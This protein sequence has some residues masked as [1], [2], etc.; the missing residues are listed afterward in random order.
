MHGFIRKTINTSLIVRIFLL[1][2]IC[3]SISNAQEKSDWKLAKH[4][5]Q[6]AN[7]IELLNDE[8]YEESL[9]V[10]RELLQDAIL[11]NDDKATGYAYNVI[12]ANFDALTEPDKAL[13]YYN[14]ALIYAEKIDDNK[15]LNWVNNNLGNIYC[16]DSNDYLKG[17][18]YYITSLKYS[19]KIKDSAQIVF[20]KLN[21]TWAYFDIGEFEKGAPY[22]KY[23]NKYH[24]RHG[25]DF[26]STALNL[27]N[28]MYA[29]HK[30]NNLAAKRYFE[31]AIKEGIR[32]NEKTDLSFTFQE[33]SKFLIKNNQPELAYHYLAKYD[34]L[35][36]KIRTEEK[37]NKTNITGIN[38]QVDEY[39]RELD[40]T[41]SLYR[42]KEEMLKYEKTRNKRVI[43]IMI[44]LF[45][46]SIIL[47]Y[48]FF[49]NTRLKQKNKLKDVQ[50]KIQDNLINASIDGQE[51]ERIEIAGFLHDNISAMLSSAGMHLKSFSTGNESIPE[52][53]LKTKDILEEAH[54]RVR[55]LSH[56]LLPSLL[57]R[58]GLFY[59]IED[60][61][62]KNSNSK[63]HFE[64]LSS[65]P[66]NTRY[67]QKFE[68]R[69]YFIISELLNNIS[70]HS[71]AD[72]AQVSID[73]G[74]HELIFHVHDNGKG[75]DSKKLKVEGFGLNQVRARIKNL[76]GEFIVNSKVNYG[77]SVKMRVPILY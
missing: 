67:N 60:L 38:L 11:T 8:K 75:F 70:K 54:D 43:G 31:E 36:S 45:I 15:L 58:F 20:T 42:D 26:T 34:S 23:I 63:I 57:V 50:R 33:Y 30:N 55:D 32:Q 29:N 77:T 64:Y 27:L 47:F 24:T 4:K 51:R 40:K 18:N 46:V 74:N 5:T 69:L 2:I 22:L 7:A 61:C 16:F 3:T 73:L 68:M 71:D 72:K 14:K 49:Q 76:N 28:G 53:I 52:E 48:F 10:S 21:I 12:A 1:Y 19:G 65:L 62:E 41:E 39:K 13:F 59:A 9:V 17:I 66:T 37:R 56:E 25:N 35:S 44:S 6:Y